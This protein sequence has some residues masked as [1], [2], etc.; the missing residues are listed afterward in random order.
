MTEIELRA[1]DGRAVVD[2]ANG[3]RLARLVAGGKERLIPKDAS[4]GGPTSW[5]C[6]LMAPWAGRIEGA[7][8]PFRGRMHRVRE[9]LPPHAIHGVAFDKPWD[10][11][12][13]TEDSCELT[14]AFPRGEWPFGGRVTQRIALSPG[15]LDLTAEVRATEEP[16]PLSLG[17][18]P[19]FARPADGDLSVAV[20]AGEVLVTNDQLIPTGQT[21]PVSGDADLRE[22][23]ELGDRR[24]DHVYVSPVGPAVVTWPD[25]ELAIEVTRPIT[26]IVV[27]T[28]PG[29]AC[30]EPQTA[31][32]NAPALDDRGVTSTGLLELQP[33]DLVTAATSF[34]WRPLP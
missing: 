14:L 5:G 16:M 8:V 30:V 24:L 21:R 27:Y 25:L 32:P 2:A 6:F 33:G 1:G 31:W 3:A 28:P 34:T 26:T 29:A 17:W 4:D 20:E 18:H 11:L 7:R 19:W 9:N 13:A 10:V 22:G 12:G 23:P 15:R